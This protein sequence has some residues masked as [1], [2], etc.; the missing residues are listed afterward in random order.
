MSRRQPER[1]FRELRLRVRTWWII[2]GLFILAVLLNRGGVLVFFALGEC[3]RTAGV[4]HACATAG[5][6]LARDCRSRIWPSRCNTFG[7]TCQWYGMFIIFIPGVPVSPDSDAAGADG[8]D[9][10]LSA[11]DSALHWGLMTTVFSI[12][13]AAYLLVL[14][15]ERTR[16]GRRICRPVP[17]SLPSG[18][19]CSC[20]SCC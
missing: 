11:I 8:R 18:P 15:P 19:G 7:F 13:H 10:R 20:F 14:K 3:A 16:A 2:V 9:R 17:M 6:R 1:D 5:R 12:S 4:S